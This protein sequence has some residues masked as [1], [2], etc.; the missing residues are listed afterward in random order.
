MQAL[1]FW[2]ERRPLLGHD[3]FARGRPEMLGV[4]AAA[5]P[6]LDVVEFLWASLAL[7]DEAPTANTAPVYR[8]VRFYPYAVAE[9]RARILARLAAMPAGVGLEA[10]LPEPDDPAAPAPHAALRRRSGWASTLVASL[11]LAKQGEVVLGQRSDFQTI[12][13]ART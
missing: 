12:H 9:A 13:V 11:E 10:L 5:G 8:P 7:F 6:A 3:V 1:A 4:S 2:L